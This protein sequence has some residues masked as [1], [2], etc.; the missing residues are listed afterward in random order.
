MQMTFHHIRDQAGQSV[1]EFAVVLP[2]VVMVILALADFGRAFYMSLE[3]EHAATDAA[4]LAAVDYTPSAGTLQNYLQQKLIYGEFRTG[5]G[6]SAGAQGNAQ[7]CISF[8][9][10]TPAT[11]GDPV[12]V[13]VKNDFNWVP[14][15]VIPGSVNIG[16]SATMRLEQQPSF[17]AGCTA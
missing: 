10:G 8:P 14:G 3:A 12:T 15:G 4:R 1:V 5:S 9:N 7:V 13:V 17:S 6:T 2:L 11:I 16:G